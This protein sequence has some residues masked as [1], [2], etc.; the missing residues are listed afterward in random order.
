MKLKMR[1]KIKYAFNFVK[2]LFFSG[3]NIEE[4]VNLLTLPSQ[5]N[6]AFLFPTT[7]IKLLINFLHRTLPF[8]ETFLATSE[9][10]KQHFNKV[11]KKLDDD[12][13]KKVQQLGKSLQSFNSSNCEKL[14]RLLTSDS[15]EYLISL[16]SE[17][18][19][20]LEKRIGELIQ[21]SLILERL[22]SNS[23]L[24]VQN[25]SEDFVSNL[26]TEYSCICLTVIDEIKQKCKFLKG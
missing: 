26:I 4:L 25:T 15:L 17:V 18:K 8:F 9:P 3:E 6:S 23:S 5:K 13:K 10:L 21:K 22:K 20:E 7:W 14:H 12:L 1:L 16:R 2:I 11:S 24:K 19:T